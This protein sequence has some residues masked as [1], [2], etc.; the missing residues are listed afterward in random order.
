MAYFL[1]AGAGGY[2]GSRLAWRLLKQ[3]HRVRGLVRDAE[4]E[5][6][7]RLAA[8]GMVVWTGDVT[9]PDTLVGIADGIDYVYNLTSRSVLS[10]G[11]LRETLVA[12][13][14]NLIAACS[15]ARRVRAYIFT[16]SGAPY[17]DAGP[18]LVTEDTAV[19][20]CC[21]LGQVM[22]E[23]EQA[24]MSLVQQHHFPAMI[25]RL[26]R[27]YGPERDLLQG[28][29]NHTATIFGDG[30]NY[31]SRIHIDDLLA[32][33]EQMPLRGQPGAVYNIA[34]DEPLRLSD[35][36]HEIWQRFGIAP[37]QPYSR[38]Q[39][40]RSGL[41]P[42]I[43][44]MSSA[45]VRMSNARLKHDLGVNLRYPSYRAWLDE[46]FRAAEQDMPIETGQTTAVAAF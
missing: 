29:L 20:P 3:G 32:V 26:G 45:S 18:E 7:Q 8:A 35:L 43:V 11:A 39:A 6:V 24:V 44:E 33:L 25:L 5:E 22:M 36:Y 9:R 27:I 41:D 30:D 37:P 2:V 16:S 28:V 12:G 10:N 31:V 15:R 4:T 17:G 46:Q 19:S 23:A 1:I 38:E 13:N 21:P 40:L 34:D 14:Q 42:T